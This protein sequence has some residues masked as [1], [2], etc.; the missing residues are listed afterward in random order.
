M[1]LLKISSV[2]TLNNPLQVYNEYFNMA[3]NYQELITKV[4]LNDDNARLI[5]KNSRHKIGWGRD[6]YTTI[7]IGYIWKL[8]RKLMKPNYSSHIINSRL[9]GIEYWEPRSPVIM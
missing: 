6:Y 1:I 2:Y 3:N 5:S 9:R 7:R 8:L 4:T